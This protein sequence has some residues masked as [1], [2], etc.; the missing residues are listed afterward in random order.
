VYSCRQCLYCKEEDS[1]IADQSNLSYL[2]LQRTLDH[3]N[4][5]YENVAD[6]TAKPRQTN[7]ECLKFATCSRS[8]LK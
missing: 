3:A 5:R 2:G 6:A 8:V 4:T 1:D 7:R